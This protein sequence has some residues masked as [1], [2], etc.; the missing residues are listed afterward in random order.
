MTVND[1]APE[2]EVK[3][4]VERLNLHI[5]EIIDWHF[6]SETGCPFW[7][8]WAKNA[9]WNPLEEVRTIEDFSKFPHFEDNF[10]RDLPHEQW[11]P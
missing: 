8:D 5:Q 10:L 6:S 1:L 9:G 7:L 11:I 4:A 2:A 3:K